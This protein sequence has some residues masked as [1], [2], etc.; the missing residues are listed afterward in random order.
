[1]DTDNTNSRRHGWR[2]RWAAIG[3]AVAVSL[4]GGG[5]LIADAAAG[6]DDS[7]YVPIANCRLFDTRPAPRPPAGPKKTPLGPGESNVYTQPVTGTNGDCTIPPDAVGVSMNVTITDPTAQ[8]NLRLFP[9][10]EATP[11]TSNLNWLPGQS[12]TPNKVDVKL[13]PDGKMKLFNFNGT[14]NV[15]A[16]VF[17]YYTNL[18]LKELEATKVTGQLL[19]PT[20]VKVLATEAISF[21]AA[22]PIAPES[23]LFKMGTIEVYAKCLYDTT[24]GSIQGEMYVRTSADGAMMEGNDDLPGTGNGTIF[25]DVATIESN[26]QLDTQSTSVANTASFNENEGAITAADAKGYNVLTAIG[27]KQGSPAGGNGPFGAGNVCL[28]NGVTL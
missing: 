9:A 13:S 18:T 19:A 11:L 15:L 24:I 20:P 4:G 21:D 26:R 3:A 5:F 23:P 16:D 25:L 22:R 17:G 27:V 8:S 12:P 28:F 7:T 1:M 10:D 2:A 6:D 14:V